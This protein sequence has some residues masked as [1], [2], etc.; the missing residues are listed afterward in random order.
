MKKLVHNALKF[1][2]HGRVEVRADLAPRPGHVRISV[3]DTGIGIAADDLKTIFEMFRQLEPAPTRRFGGVG[4]GL[5]I[6]QRLLD[7]LGG[8]IHVHSQPDHGSVFAVTV[9]VRAQ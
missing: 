8:E 4:L 6:V 3:S 2:H 1:T 7:V 5:Y 9:P